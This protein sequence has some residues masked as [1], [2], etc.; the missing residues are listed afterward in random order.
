MAS[1]NSERSYIMIKPDGVQRGLVIFKSTMKKK[2]KPF[3]LEKSLPDLR[4][5]DTNWLP[6]DLST[7][8]WNVHNNITLT[9]LPNPFTKVS[10]R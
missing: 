9:S 8:L 1:Q 3:R 6:S 4:K 2:L 5:R 10:V 7:L